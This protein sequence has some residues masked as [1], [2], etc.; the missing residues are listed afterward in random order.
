MAE[1]LAEI[2][3]LDAAIAEF[4]GQEA[5][6]RHSLHGLI[7]S[8]PDPKV[9]SVRASHS[10]K[11]VSVVD[12]DELLS[13]QQTVVSSRPTKEYVSPAEARIK[14]YHKKTA[15]LVMERTQS[16]PNLADPLQDQPISSN[17]HLPYKAN[18]ILTGNSP[19]GSWSKSRATP[20][21]PGQVGG[22]GLHQKPGSGNSTPELP[23]RLPV[24]NGRT[25]APGGPPTPE[26][27][28]INT[29]A[30]KKSATN[31]TTSSSSGIYANVS[32]LVGQGSSFRPP[33]A[34]T[35]SVSSRQ[36][37]N[38][39]TLPPPPEHTILKTNS[40]A[41][42]RR[43]QQMVHQNNI[44]LE[45]GG[46]KGIS[47]ADQRVME[48][49]QQFIKKHPSATLLVTADIHASPEHG[50]D[51]GRKEDD[52]FEP[53]PDYEVDSEE[54]EKH[55]VSASKQAAVKSQK[56]STPSVSSSASSTNVVRQN[57]GSVTVISISSEKSQP[58]RN[59]ASPQ[60]VSKSNG[61]SHPSPQPSVALSTR[62]SPGNS[63]ASSRRSSAQSGFSES[64][65]G[66]A[67]E[68]SFFTG[69]QA[70]PAPPPP[71][72]PPP[73][74]PPPLPDYSPGGT[75]TLKG[76]KEA[77]AENPSPKPVLP[78]QVSAED[79]LAA[80]ANRKSRIE[81]VGPKVSAVKAPPLAKSTHE[82][83]Q[84]ALL[85]AVARRKSRLESDDKSLVEDIE[86]KLN[87]N[88]K[89]QAT[90]F[91]RNTPKT[92]TPAAPATTSTSSVGESQAASS[93]SSPASA[94]ST[95]T[96][97]TT[98]TSTAVV[99]AATVGSPKEAGSSVDLNVP[100]PREILSRF[101]PNKAKTSPAVQS[102]AAVST[103][104]EPTPVIDFR[105]RL[106][107]VAASTAGKT[108]PVTVTSQVPKSTSEKAP[109]TSTKTMVAS[110][111]SMSELKSTPSPKP[112][113]PHQAPK[114]T[115]VLTESISSV[116]ISSSKAPAP[117]PPASKSTPPPAV[118]PK[119]TSQPAPSASTTTK[120]TTQNQ[121][122]GSGLPAS[123]GSAADYIALAEKA[124]LEYLKKKASGNM[125]ATVSKKGPV[126]ITPMGKK[127]SS[128]IVPSK[129]TQKPKTNGT[130][131]VIQSTSNGKTAEKKKSEVAR[132]EKN[133]NV[134]VKGVTVDHSHTEQTVNGGR[135]ISPP[136]GLIPPPPA[137]FQDVEDAASPPSVPRGVVIDIVP[138]PS[139][140]DSGLPS[141]P[142]P[143]PTSMLRQEDAA[144]LVSSVSS[145]STLSSEHGN[146]PGM[147][148]GISIEDMIA[149]PPPPPPAFEDD[150]DL[151]DND[152]DMSFIPPPPQ[153][154][155][156][157]A[158]AN[159]SKSLD[160]NLRPFVDKSVGTWSCLD[161]LDWLDSLGL[162]QYRTSFAKA[163]VDGSKLLDM[164]RTEFIALGV[165]QVGHRMN[166][167]RSVKKLTIAASTNL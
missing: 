61:S 138:P 146:S 23:D 14:K 136:P 7:D 152:Q 71:P 77:R 6:R 89:L 115:K 159:E 86:A 154:L 161:V 44:A 40:S 112:A 157:D 31:S 48:H 57:R 53:E 74:P 59:S 29:S 114:S 124:R 75:L 121:N 68:T 108:S 95:T 94:S 81:S 98:T 122:S 41:H 125:V 47:F 3:K 30:A 12:Y 128:Q 117:P 162:P 64:D 151:N 104:T 80:V 140:F 166:L 78:S 36:Q 134:P 67:R 163:H 55:P 164:G 92:D 107:P 65:D 8:A 100:S 126:E 27:V 11:R 70:P 32:G 19:A 145:L 132:Q 1:G 24:N 26:V 43:N 120:T 76:R 113:A 37:E 79:I 91:N 5:V 97:T 150:E 149:P 56:E 143:L 144:S 129:E 22:R 38:S 50:Q 106:K 63:L 33:T 130:T 156:I 160:K 62:V 139:S 21:A 131:P 119:N 110:N 85:A 123:Q 66:P 127:N 105:S 49:A 137:G 111:S 102:K 4:E 165:T 10:A 20:P 88:K 93:T 101:E 83:N 45:E 46:S 18:G 148:P 87:R 82:L 54:E 16:T 69:A 35:G 90:K 96:T 17:G 147:R 142:P 103:S 28:R 51:K 73:P 39:G 58:A 60:A 135:P 109:S 116:K 158:N 72:G 9:A 13:G 133:G 84:E 15:P 34:S 155:E 118:Q 25:G 141:P 167:E 42:N 153:F 99:S 52:V 2:E